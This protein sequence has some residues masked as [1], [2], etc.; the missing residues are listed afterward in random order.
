MLTALQALCFSIKK[1]SSA[2]WTGASSY[3]YCSDY[4][5]PIKA[6]KKSCGHKK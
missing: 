1:C 4:G 6:G 2:C 3:Q 5:L